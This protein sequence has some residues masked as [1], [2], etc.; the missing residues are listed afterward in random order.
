MLYR[1]ADDKHRRGLQ[2]IFDGHGGYKIRIWFL[3]SAREKQWLDRR[4][5]DIMKDLFHHRSRPLSRLFGPQDQLVPQFAPSSANQDSQQ[6]HLSSRKRKRNAQQKRN[7]QGASDSQAPSHQERHKPTSRAN[8]TAASNQN[9]Y[10]RQRQDSSIDQSHR[11]PSS[12]PDEYQDGSKPGVTLS[13]QE[14][15]QRSVRPQNEQSVSE[16]RHR[17][18]K[19]DQ[20]QQDQ[21]SSRAEDKPSATRP[22]PAIPRVSRNPFAGNFPASMKRMGIAADRAT[23]SL[24]SA[25]LAKAGPESA[26]KSMEVDKE[27]TKESVISD[28]KQ[29]AVYDWHSE[30]EEEDVKD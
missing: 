29:Q 2:R 21:A 22:M 8:D 12:R 18:P 15:H 1:Q 23:E 10:K 17:D 14:G 16:S 24:K 19:F 5:L 6:K 3:I 9:V 25:R 27:G 4:C 11:K 13:N 30:E 28:F 7:D 20:K 26:E